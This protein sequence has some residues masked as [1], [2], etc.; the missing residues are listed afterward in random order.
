MAFFRVFRRSLLRGSPQRGLR[1][2]HRAQAHGGGKVRLFVGAHHIA[3]VAQQGFKN[4]L[5]A[6]FG[7]IR[8]G[9]Q[10]WCIRKIP[11]AQ[12]DSGGWPGNAALR[13]SG[14]GFGLKLLLIPEP[15]WCYPQV[16]TAD[17]QQAV[18]RAQ[19]IR[20]AE[21]EL[22]F[23]HIQRITFRRQGGGKADHQAVIRHKTGGGKSHFHITP[24]AR[25]GMLHGRTGPLRRDPC[26]TAKHKIHCFPAFQYTLPSS[27]P[28]RR[29]D[30][31]SIPLLVQKFADLGFHGTHL[32]LKCAGG[33]P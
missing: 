6:V 16:M 22:V 28:Y 19:I 3:A 9:G 4:H 13:H 15:E 30:G 20:R 26:G 32:A 31:C 18:H 10:P 11:P 5:P 8:P 33:Y 23:R 24:K 12:A 1:V 7:G 2:L 14:K 21:G 29:L 25:H 17:I 27:P